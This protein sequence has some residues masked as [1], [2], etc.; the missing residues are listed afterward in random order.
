MQNKSK[1]FIIYIMAIAAIII[2]PNR[3]N[4]E[5]FFETQSAIFNPVSNTVNF[6]VGFNQE[7]DFYT[8]DQFGRQANS[9]QYYIIGNP[10]LGYPQEFDAI[11]RGDEI[12]V[13]GNTLPIRSAFPFGQDPNSGGWGA[14]RG[15][16]PFIINGNILSFSAPISYLSDHGIPY[17]YIFGSYQYGSTTGEVTGVVEGV[18]ESEEW[19]LMLL[20]F[21][22]VGWQVKRKQMKAIR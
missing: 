14:I 18:P 10:N 19:A 5:F 20:G 1:K 16:V 22:M 3:A 17:N 7:P 2:I 11:I 13:T 6:T 21:G 4:A 15:V 9:F 12:H 8:V